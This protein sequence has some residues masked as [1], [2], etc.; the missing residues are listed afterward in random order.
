MDVSVI[1]SSF[2]VYS[3]LVGA[4]FGAAEHNIHF[5]HQV[6]VGDKL[7]I[8]IPFYMHENLFQGVC[9][10]VSYL[11][12]ELVQQYVDNFQNNV[13]HISSMV[14]HGRTVGRRTLQPYPFNMLFGG[15]DNHMSSHHYYMFLMYNWPFHQNFCSAHCGF[16]I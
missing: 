3:L 4:S 15:Y 13:S 10:S 16:G 9:L 11:I 12:P 7:Y 14:M 8:M 1:T 5:F 2:L 6:Y